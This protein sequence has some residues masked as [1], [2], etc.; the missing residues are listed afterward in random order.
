[1]RWASAVSDAASL[2][3]A[4]ASVAENVRAGLAGESADLAVVFV[5]R[6]FAPRYAEVPALLRSALPCEI[7]Y[8]CSA[9]GVIGGGHEVEQRPGI[10]LTAARLPGVSLQPFQLDSESLP[11]ADARPGAWHARLGVAPVPVPQFLLLADPFTFPAE[12]LLEGLDYAYPKSTKVG[13]LASGASAPG[14]NALYLGG[15][16]QRA[17]AIGVALSGNV[18][19]DTVVAQGCRP[20]GAPLRITRCEGN[21][22]HELDGK[23]PLQVLQELY[24]RLAEEDRGLMQ[25]A[26]FLGLLTDELDGEPRP[27]QFLIRNLMG[28]DP[29]RGALAVGEELRNGQVAQFHLRDARTSAEDLKAVLGDYVAGDSGGGVRGALLFSCLGRGVHLY[30]KADHDTEIFRRLVGEVPLGGFFCNGE[31]G[32]VGSSTHLHGYTSSF[33]LFRPA[34]P[35]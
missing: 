31:I 24:E 26:L 29:E 20:I 10:A 32:P 28:I 21:V 1:M 25:Q 9:G 6:H 11:D 7:L 12:R 15:V 16:V 34:A 35:R 4:I 13:G 33:G 2:E 14:G 23:P 8:G 5:S 3:E 17:G 27:G 22:L 19:V 18:R 30:G